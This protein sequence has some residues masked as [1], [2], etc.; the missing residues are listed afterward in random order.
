MSSVGLGDCDEA[1]PWTSI[2]RQLRPEQ[3]LVS[4]GGVGG[5]G[6]SVHRPL[7][8]SPAPDFSHCS[9]LCKNPSLTE[10]YPVIPKRIP[11][12]AGGKFSQ[13]G[14]PFESP[15]RTASIPTP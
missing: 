6:H 4:L 10:E 2:S 11:S 1:G 8:S 9:D 5:A 13:L 15:Y 7:L 3:I 12:G 14:S